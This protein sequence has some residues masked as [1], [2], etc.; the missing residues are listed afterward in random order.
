MQKE[1][2]MPVDSILVS[3]AVVTMFAIFAVVLAWGERQSQSLQ[4]VP[5]D[6]DRRRRSF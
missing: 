2:V 6:S 5:A 1:V 4:Q 3:V